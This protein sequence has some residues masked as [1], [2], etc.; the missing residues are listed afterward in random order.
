MPD[1]PEPSLR[2]LLAR[3]RIVLWQPVD[4]AAGDQEAT[5]TKVRLLTAVAMHFNV[6][7]VSDFGGRAGAV[8]GEGLVEQAVAAAF[9]SF[10][11]VDPHPDP[12][13]KAAMPLRGI[14]QGHPFND[15]NKRT[16]FLLAA[17]YLRRMGYPWPA[18][19]IEEQVIE[20]CLRVS[21]GR[22]RDIHEMAV[23]LRHFWGASDISR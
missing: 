8:R 22:I 2:D 3:L 10:G 14:T 13:E 19:L 4:F 12:F 18:G 15:G 16:G 20:F 7:S 11:G 23:I 5:I 9:Q 1:D 6:L 17:Y 21:A